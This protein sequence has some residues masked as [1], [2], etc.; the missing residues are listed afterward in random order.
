[1]AERVG[2]R[3]LFTA[4]LAI[5]AVCTWLMWVLPGDETIPYHIAW[6]SFALLY[7]VG[8]WRLS[9]AVGGLVLCTVA[10][11]AVLINSVLDEH[12]VWQEATEIPLMSVL[13]ILS[14]WHVRR[15]QL[16]L[17]TVTSMAQ[18][19]QE[20]AANRERLTRLTSHEMRTPLTIARGYVELLHDR[21]AD[22][23]ERRDL[24]VVADELSRLTRVTDRLLRVIRLEGGADMTRVDVDAVLQET[25]ER[26]AQV[27]DRRWVVEAGAGDIKGSR[28][29]LRAALD[30]LVEN[31]VRYTDDGDIVR[32]TGT[33][34]PDGWVEIGVGDSG[35][36]LTPELVAAI[37]SG[38]VEPS[39]NQDGL[40]QNGL[41]LGLV[42]GVV[43]ARGG[44]L[45]AGISP[46][47]GALLVMEVPARPRSLGTVRASDEDDAG[48]AAAASRGA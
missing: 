23:E 8:D 33:S 13:M 7:A 47:G 39:P 11:G 14:V 5:A 25:A 22:P 20:Q 40:S 1:M 24:A 37:N 36:G 19:E 28:G 42:R 32:L 9:W 30:T 17:L 15:R 3:T 35:P 26:W 43:S 31:A 44:R 6:A 41:G 46:D 18:Q 29:R 34:K 45:R 16:A 27:V 38:A 48:L 10:T 2:A 12:I 4:W 21:T